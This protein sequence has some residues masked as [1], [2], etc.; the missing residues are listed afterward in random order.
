MVVPVVKVASVPHLNS[1]VLCAPFE[2][3]VPLIVAV[4]VVTDVAGVVVVDGKGTDGV[5]NDKIEPLIGPPPEFVA[6]TLK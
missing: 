3:P 5:T 2:V 6:F 1:I 4:V